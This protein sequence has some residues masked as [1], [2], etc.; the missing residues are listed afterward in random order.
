LGQFFQD[1]LAR[2]LGIDFHISLP[3]EFSEA[4]IARIEPIRLWSGLV[5]SDRAHALPRK[6]VFGMLN[7]R[8]LTGRAFGNPRLRNPADF[9]RSPPLRAVEIPSVNGIGDARSIAQSHSEFA[10]GE[11]TLG[12]ASETLS[13]L[14]AEPVA[15]TKGSEDPVLCTETTFLHG[16]MK[17]S[18]RFDR[19]SSRVAFCSPGAGGSF[20]FV[21]PD[22]RVGMAYIMN[23]MGGYLADD[24]RAKAL[25]DATYR[26][27]ARLGPS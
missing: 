2:P 25:R 16:F 5:S 15:P 12:L 18:R 8:S 22:A 6:M 9:N 26:S 11:N 23:Q 21:D 14:M 3:R 20:E 1:E 7:R 19:A 10:T 4:R 27:L 13:S 17:P 24:P